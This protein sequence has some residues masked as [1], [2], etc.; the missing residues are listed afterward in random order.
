M[1]L[2]FDLLTQQS[3]SEKKWESVKNEG[4]AW[5]G[6]LMWTIISILTA[7]LISLAVWV[8][9]L[10]IAQFKGGR[11]EVCRFNEEKERRIMSEINSQMKDMVTDTRISLLASQETENQNVYEVINQVY[12]DIV[13]NV[14]RS[15]TPA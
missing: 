10:Q 7:A 2:K 11:S 5:E 8:A 4:Y 12:A 14:Q 6:I 1:R 15:S 9:K 13:D 3:V